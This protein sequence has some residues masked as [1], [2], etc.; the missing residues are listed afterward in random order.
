MSGSNVSTGATPPHK[1]IK[2]TCKNTVKWFW[3]IHN[4]RQF[5]LSK[6]MR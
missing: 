2:L 3:D 6:I 1:V 5:V 4:G